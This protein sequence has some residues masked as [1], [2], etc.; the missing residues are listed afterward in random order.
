MN[1]GHNLLN[2]EHNQLNLGDSLGQHLG[3]TTAYYAAHERGSGLGGRRFWDQHLDGRHFMVD[4]S[5]M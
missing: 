1:F 2:L 4:T 3:Q 5:E